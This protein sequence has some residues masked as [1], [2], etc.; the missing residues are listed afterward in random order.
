VRRASEQWVVGPAVCLVV[1]LI[2]WA[3]GIASGWS[4]L[5]ILLGGILGVIIARILRWREERKVTEWND[6]LN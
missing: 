6:S 4:V 2:L 1:G 5:A 3:A